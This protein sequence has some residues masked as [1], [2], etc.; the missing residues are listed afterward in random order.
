MKLAVQLYSVRES[1][2]KKGL[3][4]VLKEISEAGYAGVEF[5]GNFG[6]YE[7]K[8]LRLV[9]NELNL[10]AMGAHVG[11]DV[12]E[13]GRFDSYLA[14]DLKILGVEYVNVPY[15][16]LSSINTE[17]AIERI[18]SACAKCKAEGFKAGY[19]N[20]A[21]EF[22][23]AKDF[24]KELMENSDIGWEADTFWL[25]AANLDV[26][27]YL[28]KMKKYVYL[29]HIKEM[30]KEGVS[31][32]NPVVGSGV[33]GAKEALAFGKRNAI[34]WAVLEVENLDMPEKDYLQQSYQFMIKNI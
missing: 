16:D 15:I 8:D 22:D 28:E 31:A 12:F 17:Q 20:H 13:D 7:M 6:G 26:I 21:F 1:I 30:A 27:E 19:H 10:Q 5:A 33:V 11:L 32:P 29:L 34:E 3:L 18:V 25:K 24:I 23:G 2:D 9:L 4:P 14:H